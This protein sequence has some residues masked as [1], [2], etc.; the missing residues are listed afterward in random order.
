MMVGRAWRDAATL[1]LLALPLGWAVPDGER[2][3]KA[4]GSSATKQN[5]GGE[6]GGGGDGMPDGGYETIFAA[7]GLIVG[8]P[9]MMFL[10]YQK[11]RRREGGKE[12]PCA[13]L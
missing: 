2:V 9:L 10:V 7:I 12:V 13:I 11:M 8:M 4:G 6:A 5:A 1:L 3:L